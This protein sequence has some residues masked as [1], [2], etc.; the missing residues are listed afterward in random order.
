MTEGSGAKDASRT[1]DEEERAPRNDVL[2]GLGELE[3]RVTLDWVGEHLPD[4]GGPRTGSGACTGLSGS[5]SRS[6]WPRMS[7]DTR[8]DRR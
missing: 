8:S 6:A 4:V 1:P 2:A 7:V 5:A 3:R